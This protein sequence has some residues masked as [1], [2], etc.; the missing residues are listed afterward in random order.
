MTGLAVE[1]EDSL[2]AGQA[3]CLHLVDRS[4]AHLC[5]VVVRKVALRPTITWVTA[6]VTDP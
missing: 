4:V 6:E 5:P 1:V 3:P 2:V